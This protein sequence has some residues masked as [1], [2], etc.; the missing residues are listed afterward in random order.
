MVLKGEAVIARTTRSGRLQ[1]R[2]AIEGYLLIAPW[3]I[4]FLAFTLGP[5]AASFYYS[6]T[7][8]IVIQP[9]RWIGLGN[10]VQMFTADP[11]FW[12]SLYNT[13]YYTLLSVPLGMILGL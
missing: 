6:L 13:A 1:R 3:L 10:Y 8:Y 5:L 9:P 2:R 12:I 11:V 4:G 7:D